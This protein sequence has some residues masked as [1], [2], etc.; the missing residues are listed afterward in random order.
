MVVQNKKQELY[1]VVIPV[2]NSEGVVAE[3]VVRTIKFFEEK[4]YK[5]EII[6]INDGSSDNS[7]NVI[8]DLA[9][10]N[11]SIKAINLLHNY[12]QHNANLCGFRESS[13]DY[14]VTMD[15]DLQNPPEE[16]SK[17]IEAASEDY[18]LVIGKFKEKKHSFF[19]RF[20]IEIK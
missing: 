8:S 7:W 18:D 16:I 6:L 5:Y 10:T 4:D 20:V 2:F 12:G 13:G 19:R 14:I 1:S 11:K 3:T 9:Q 17:L 15:D